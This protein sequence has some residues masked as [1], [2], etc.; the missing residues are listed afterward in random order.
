MEIRRHDVVDFAPTDGAQAADPSVFGRQLTRSAAGAGTAGPQAPDVPEAIDELA[1]AVGR[2]DERA[3][4]RLT[5]ALAQEW[6]SETSAFAGLAPRAADP[7]TEEIEAHAAWALATVCEHARDTEVA[8]T[9]QALYRGIL[10]SIAHCDSPR[11]MAFAMLAAAA[12]LRARPG[13]RPSAEILE[14]G[15]ALFHHL[16]APERRPLPSWF[17]AVAGNAYARLPQALIEAGEAL[18]RFD[19]RATGRDTLAWLSG[20]GGAEPSL[21]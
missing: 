18:A 1:R 20:R 10:P 13:H 5:K 6:T 3:M 7:R 17:E 4:R 8:R 16:L 21:A 2:R 19:W 14:Q 11:A 12:Y 15:G 9:A